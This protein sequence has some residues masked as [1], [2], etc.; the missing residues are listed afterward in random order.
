MSLNI[1]STEDIY[2]GQA[3]LRTVPGKSLLAN[4]SWN[5]HPT[6]QGRV[7]RINVRFLCNMSLSCHIFVSIP[8]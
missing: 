2:R 8:F 3:Y 4:I 7:V 6:L 1:E 5:L